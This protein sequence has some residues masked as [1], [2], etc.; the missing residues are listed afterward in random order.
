MIPR[1]LIEEIDNLC[2]DRGVSLDEMRAG[3]S[4][5]AASTRQSVMMKLKIRHFTPE[6]IADFLDLKKSVVRANLV[7]QKKFRDR[8]TSEIVNVMQEEINGHTRKER[9]R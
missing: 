5:K 2:R 7:H 4:E 3:T 6:A 8:K 9:F 1:D